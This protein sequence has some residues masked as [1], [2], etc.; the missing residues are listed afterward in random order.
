MTAI[1]FSKYRRGPVRHATSSSL[2]ATPR[3]TQPRPRRWQQPPRSRI[4]SRI[5]LQLRCRQRRPP[6]PPTLLL[7]LHP[8]L[9]Q[10]LMKRNKICPRTPLA[11]SSGHISS[12]RPGSRRMRWSPA[13]TRQAC[14]SVHSC[15]RIQ[16]N[17]SGR[18]SFKRTRWNGATIFMCTSCNHKTNRLNQAV[19]HQRAK[20]SHEPFAW[21]DPLWYEAGTTVVNCLFFG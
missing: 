2:L 5:L 17:Q 9:L 15:S 4:P 6:S 8:P 13:L 16:G 3:W 1:D 14:R 10:E 20:W 12:P 21:T 19:E 11:L 7:R 18:V